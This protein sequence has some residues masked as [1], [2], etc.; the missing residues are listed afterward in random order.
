MWFN[1]K[2]FFLL[3]LWLCAALP[4]SLGVSFHIHGVIVS[5]DDP[6][7]NGPVSS[8]QY[9]SWIWTAQAAGED[10]LLRGL[11]TTLETIA[12]DQIEHQQWTSRHQVRILLEQLVCLASRGMLFW[13]TK[14]DV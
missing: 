10:K 3:L 14:N 2:I 11:Y 13:L 9:E 1:A 5:M 8:I 4:A 7:G 6:S 12:S